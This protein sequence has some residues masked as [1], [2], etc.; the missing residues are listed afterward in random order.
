MLGVAQGLEQLEFRAGAK[1]IEIDSRQRSALALKPNDWHPTANEPV[2]PAR[3]FSLS[4]AGDQEIHLQLG[5]GGQFLDSL[6][7]LVNQ[8][9]HK[10]RLLSGLPSSAEQLTIRPRHHHRDLKTV[11][12]EHPIRAVLLVR[13]PEAFSKLNPAR[14]IQLTDRPGLD[15]HQLQHVRDRLRLS[16]LLRNFGLPNLGASEE[17]VT[18]IDVNDWRRRSACLAHLKRR[19]LDSAQH[20]LGAPARN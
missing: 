8:C 3:E 11:G 20:R 7:T 18:G 12:C 13:Q 17:S 14:I 15:L 10:V 6:Q 19:L 5:L 4:M 9:Q 2:L 1:T 16:L